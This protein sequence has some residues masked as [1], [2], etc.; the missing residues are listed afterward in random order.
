MSQSVSGALAWAISVLNL[1]Q[2]EALTT[3]PISRGGSDRTFYRL[4][5]PSHSALLMH[6]R[7]ERR[8]NAFYAPIGR[9]LN[10]IGVRVPEIY[11]HDAEQGFLVMEDLGDDDLWSYRTASWDVRR[12][13][14]EKTLN[15]IRHLHTYPLVSFPEKTVPLMEGF[16]AALYGWERDYFR[17]HFVEGVCRIRRGQTAD[18]AL[19]HELA[20]LAIRLQSDPQALIH[21]DFQSQNI[22]I[23]HGEPVL[24]DFQGM[25]RGNPLYDLASLLYDPYVMLTEAERIALLRYYYDAC[26][27]QADWT[28]FLGRFRDGAAQRLMQALGAYGFLGLVKGRPEFLGHIQNGLH[29]LE[30]ATREAENLSLLHDLTKQCRQIIAQ[31]PDFNSP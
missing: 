8:E 29:H 26:G 25:R 22:M 3:T 14:Y 19:E 5:W 4:S 20:A 2:A 12:P 6:Y 24:I 9:F 28:G 7:F 15:V 23:R 16:D 21:R 1:P 13:L 11:G 10:E 18:S 27:Y 30:E 17:E 31:R